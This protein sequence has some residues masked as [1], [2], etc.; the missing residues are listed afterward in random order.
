[1]LCCDQRNPRIHKRLLRI[2]DVERCSPPDP[3]FVPDAI[4][5]GLRFRHLFLRR[6][7]LG[8][9]CQQLAPRLHDVGACL[10]A[11]LFKRRALLG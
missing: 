5:R 9:S 2:Q 10:V 1:M 7:D 6:L 11:N 8:P 3:R 4:E